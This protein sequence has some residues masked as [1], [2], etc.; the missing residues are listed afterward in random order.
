VKATFGLNTTSVMHT[1]DRMPSRSTWKLYLS[2]R[3]AILGV[4]LIG[5]LGLFL[6][7][8]LLQQVHRHL[9]VVARRRVIRSQRYDVVILSLV[10]AHQRVYDRHR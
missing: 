8:H 3:T 5:D 6:V 9:R 1:K 10:L 2:Q 4:V 7:G